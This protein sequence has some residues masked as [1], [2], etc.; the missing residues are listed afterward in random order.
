[1]LPETKSRPDLQSPE[2]TPIAALT[3]LAEAEGEGSNPLVSREPDSGLMPTT[4]GRSG[5]IGYEPSPES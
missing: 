1:M 2:P 3:L 4:L 5:P